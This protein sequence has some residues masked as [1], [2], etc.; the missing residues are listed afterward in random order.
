MLAADSREPVQADSARRL[1]PTPERGN[2]K[3]VLL[4][5]HLE[6]YGGT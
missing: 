5:S 2:S 6:L 3:A 4:P 1:H